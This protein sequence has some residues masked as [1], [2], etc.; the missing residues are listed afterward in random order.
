MKGDVKAL[1]LGVGLVALGL[2]LIV[3]GELQRVHPRSE[4]TL[5]DTIY[6]SAGI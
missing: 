5:S 2:I 1:P 3:T 4:I 6:H